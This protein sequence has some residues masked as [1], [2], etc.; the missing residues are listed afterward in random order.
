M[1]RGLKFPCHICPD[2][3]SNKQALERHVRNVHVV[4]VRNFKCAVCGS[5]FKD[6]EYLARHEKLHQ[7]AATARRSDPCAQC[8]KVLASA[9]A[10]AVHVKRVHE[11]DFKHTCED[12]GKSFP[13]LNT[14]QIHA[15]MAHMK[16]TRHVCQVGHLANRIDYRHPEL[17]LFLSLS[18]CKL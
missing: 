16:G 1:Y 8:G 14:L 4:S 17:F 18:F 12:C 6:K 9:R 3:L 10:L 7:T 11:R 15:E 2:V 13:F 5:A